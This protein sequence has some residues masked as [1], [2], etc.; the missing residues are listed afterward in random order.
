MRHTLA[1]ALVLLAACQPRPAAS[2][3]PTPMNDAAPSAA[4]A[5][6]LVTT[7]QV[8]PTADS[9]VFTLQVTNA[10]LAPVTLRFSSGQTYDFTVTDG[11]RTVWEWGA[12]R[13]FTQ[14]LR[15]E[16]LAPGDTRSWR[17]VWRPSA[18]LRGHELTVT[19]RLLS[20]SHPA[21]RTQGFRLP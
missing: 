10:A 12:E 2:T 6:E 11:G 14:A 5:G 18:A 7:L 21:E 20:A 4:P 17:E 19:A 13:M 9:V 15:A 3:P 16:T 1:A 8:A